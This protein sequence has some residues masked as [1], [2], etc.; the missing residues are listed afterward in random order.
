MRNRGQLALGLILVL[1]GIWF[2]AQRQVPALSHWM[3]LY[4]NW[5]MNIVAIGGVIFL[6]GLLVGAPG[7]AIPAAIVSG[8]GGILVY[9]NVNHDFTSWSYM[10]A[11]IP[12]F[13]GVG[14][15]LAGLLSNDTRQARSGLNL[16]ATS[17]VMFVIFAAIFGRLSILGPYGPALLL[18]LAGI[19]IIA[20]GFINRTRE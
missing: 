4:M 14:N 3:S 12:G 18:I 7:M 8:I 17:A 2:I 11:L 20:R 13:I 19:W 5:P 6:I 9:Q 15:I 1:L 10:W 16:I